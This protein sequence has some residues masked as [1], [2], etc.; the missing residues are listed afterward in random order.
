MHL[1]CK[2][3]AIICTLEL[4]TAILP[5]IAFVFYHDALLSLTRSAEVMSEEFPVSSAPSVTEETQARVPTSIMA[6]RWSR[7]ATI[8]S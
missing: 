7:C 4:R 1:I 8:T 6:E 2:R 5:L 3:C